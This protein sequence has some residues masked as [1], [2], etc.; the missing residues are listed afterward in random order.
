[1][2]VKLRA[3]MMPPPGVARPAGD[4]LT[5]LAEALEERI[6]EAAARSPNPGGRTFQRL[7]QVEY[8]RSIQDL[9]GLE[10]DAAA[11]LPPEAL[12]AE[13]EARLV[14]VFDPELA[15]LGE[16]LGHRLGVHLSGH[17]AAKAERLLQ[18][19]EAPERS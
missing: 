6:D 16:W 11:L 9:L 13:L 10:I 12:D 19:P 5:M 2:I 1:M 18:S 8:A 17:E 7:N 3:G 4:S 14:A 15:R